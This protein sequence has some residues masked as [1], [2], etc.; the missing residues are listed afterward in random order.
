MRI[1]NHSSSRELIARSC[2]DRLCS[3]NF[4][5]AWLFRFLLIGR[6]FEFFQNVLCF[7]S[8][9]TLG[10]FAEESAEFLA[11]L[12]RFLFCEVEVHKLQI[13]FSVSGFNFNGLVEFLLSF[14]GTPHLAINRT[15][16]KMSQGRTWIFA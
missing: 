1:T 16:K 2:L 7:R 12:R 11:S 9:G 5:F 6:A 8:K 13:C 4:V 15:E 3:L 14:A 10:K